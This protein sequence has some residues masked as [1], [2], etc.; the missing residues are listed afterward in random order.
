MQCANPNVCAP[1]M[2]KSKRNLNLDRKYKPLTTWHTANLFG[3]ND[4]ILDQELVQIIL[5]ERAIMS[6]GLRPFSAKSAL[7]WLRSKVGLGSF[8][9]T[10]E[11]DDESPSRLPN[12]TAYCGPPAYFEFNVITYTNVFILK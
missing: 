5:P 10:L 8:P 4:T 7:S 11:A 9:V 1:E 3:P 2:F 6:L 12:S